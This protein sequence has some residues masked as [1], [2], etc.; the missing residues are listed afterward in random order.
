MAVM[1]ADT[2]DV[3]W[4]TYAELGHARGISTASATRLAFRRKW[5]R[6]GGNDGIARVA[7]PA[8]EAQ[9]RSDR[10]H[11]IGDDDRGDITRVVSALETAVASLTKRAEA[12]ESRADRAEQA[13]STERERADRAEARTDKAEQGRDAERTRADA[14]RDQIEALRLKLAQVEAEGAASDVQAAELTAQLK[15]ARTDAQE[16]RQADAARKARGR[17]ARL[18][19]AWLKG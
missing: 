7:V 10:T 17:W 14:L 15:Q 13:I 18:R 12:A 8:A 19:Q 3:R 2:D 6:Q 16:L 11:D 5:R 4:M 9:Q 1:D